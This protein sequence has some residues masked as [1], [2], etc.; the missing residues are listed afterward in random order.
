[1]SLRQNLPLRISSSVA[2]QSQ[3]EQ[4]A[5]DLR[6]A[7][8]RTVENVAENEKP[9]HRLLPR[10]EL[11]RILNYRSLQL[12]FMELLSGAPLPGETERFVIRR[13]DA[14]L[15]RP[16]RMLLLAMF[17]YENREELLSLYLE[18]L[19]ALLDDNPADYDHVIPSD[20]SIPFTTETLYISGV[21]ERHHRY[22]FENQAIFKPVTL[23]QLAHHRINNGE[24]LPFIG[25]QEPIKP[26][27]SGDVMKA[28]IAHGHWEIEADH[29]FVPGNPNHPKV[30]ALK[31][32]KDVGTVRNMNEATRDFIMELNILKELRNSEIKHDTI[33]LDLGSITVLGENKTPISH[34][35]IFDL[36]SFSLNDY[37][38]NQDLAQGHVKQSHLLQKL[39]D[40]VEAL[41]F[42]HDRLDTLHL[43]IKPD[44]ILIFENGGI[45][46]QYDQIWKLSNFGLARKITARQ[47]DTSSQALTAT[48]S[49]LA[50]PAV[51][52]AG[53]YQAPEIHEQDTSQARRRTDVWSVGCVTLMVLALMVE[54]SKAVISLESSL[55]VH[56]L[57]DDSRHP[58]FYI[59][60]DTYKWK[61]RM[62]YKYWYLPRLTP[63]K[64]YITS[65]GRQF[66]AALHPNLIEWSNLLLFESCARKVHQQFVLKILQVIFGKVLR[67]DRN[68]RLKAHALRKRL[69]DIQQDWEM[70]ELVPESYSY[71][72][73]STN[74]HLEKSPK[75]RKPQSSLQG[76]SKLPYA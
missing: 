41:S 2:S 71:N 66:W 56:F 63:E 75:F 39:V 15:G 3:A 5:Q 27:S 62:A 47:R 17:L 74:L 7:V 64:D 1:M 69:A 28:K 25:R 37:L 53:I 21:P 43:D 67:I 59:R 10:A 26:G 20:D 68:K 54:G 51:R 42:L 76:Q 38:R 55:L 23:Q 14:T 58:L 8:E 48:S 72:E 11:V 40:I 12:L 24:R 73:I 19:D 18:W 49:A 57:D 31:I 13:I 4:L 65:T 50:R 29:D 36:A 33:L 34:C 6:D 16:S 32:F 61:Y 9:S 46:S 35:L 70:Y 52:P 22:I 30:V 60:N 44:N 45:G